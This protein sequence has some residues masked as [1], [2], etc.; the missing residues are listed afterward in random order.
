MTRVCCFTH[1]SKGGQGG[2]ARSSSLMGSKGQNSCRGCQGTR[3]SSWK[4]STSHY[5]S[6]YQVQQCATIRW[7]CCQN[8]RFWFVESSPWYDSSPS[9]NPCSWNL[10]LSCSRVWSQ[11]LHFIYIH[12]SYLLKPSSNTFSLKVPISIPIVPTK[13]IYDLMFNYLADMRW[14]ATSVQ[15]V[16]FTA[17][18]S[19]SLSFWQGA[20][21]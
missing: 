8:C 14:P 2:T 11:M 21:L 12:L 19:F 3:V 9:F 1:R 15:R 6:W 10:W 7:R 17:L 4:S 16:M 5:T 20:N 13:V 18:E